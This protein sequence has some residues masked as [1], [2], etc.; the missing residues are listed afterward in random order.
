MRDLRDVQA[1]ASVLAPDARLLERLPRS[2]VRDGGVIPVREEIAALVGR[3]GGG[4]AA[5][6]RGGGA[7]GGEAPDAEALAA[8]REARLRRFS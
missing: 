2:V 8:L 6:H 3:G 1:G 7:S 5:A 4:D